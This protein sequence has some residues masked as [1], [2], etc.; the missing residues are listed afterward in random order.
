MQIIALSN[1]KGGCGKTTS[2]INIAASLAFLGKR[3][4]LID[5]DPQAHATFGLGVRN[6]KLENSIYNVL[7]EQP[8]KKRHFIEDVIVPIDTH[9]DMVPSHI[10]LSTIEQEFT[11]KD[12]SVSILHETLSAL[13]FPYEVIVIDCPPSLGFLTFNALRAAQTVIVP[14]DLSSF[15]LMGVGKLLSMIELIRVKLQHTPK[16][17]ALPTMVDMRTN[18]S[19]HMVEEIRL[20]FGEN[21]LNSGIRQTITVKES[22]AKGIPLLKFNKKSKGA[23]D[24]LILTQELLN[25]IPASRDILQTQ[26][27][28]RD[29]GLSNHLCDFNLKKDGARE[30]HIVGDF[31]NWNISNQSLLWQKEEGYWQKKLSL[32]PGRYRYKFVID[33]EWVTDPSNHTLEPNPYGGLDSVLEIE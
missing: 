8:G 21:I 10:L 27:P 19:K 20:A 17:Y 29:V 16:V 9:L 2:A 6:E 3:T 15:S 11:H 5:L 26:N 23:V 14:M 4:L 33:G 7:T 18:F 31:N 22:Q 28:R 25:K 1:Q 30:V 13:S 12:E 24:Y 32:E